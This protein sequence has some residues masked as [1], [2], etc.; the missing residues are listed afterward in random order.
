[1]RKI[2]TIT[3]AGLMIAG[4]YPAYASSDDAYCRQQSDGERMSIQDITAKVADMG[5][6]VTRWKAMTDATRST[7]PT[8][9]AH[10]SR[11]SCTR[12]PVRSSNA[13]ASRKP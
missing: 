7:R 13:N 3:A 10:A 6:D 9:T 11:S 1:M 12:S 2:I 8:R 5:Y 4:A